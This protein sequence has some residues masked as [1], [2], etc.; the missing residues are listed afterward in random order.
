MRSGF[1]VYRA[2]HQDSADNLSILHQAGKC[3]VPCLTLNG[4]GSFLAPIAEEQAQEMYENVSVA[5]VAGA[6]HW[7]A[8][9]NP[10]DFVKQVLNF[11]GKH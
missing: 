5:T 2:F 6:G 7:C 8:E 11:V 9:E 3:K 4:E 1:D 10:E